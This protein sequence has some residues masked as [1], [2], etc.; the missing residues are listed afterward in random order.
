MCKEISSLCLIF[1]VDAKPLI[2]ITI[3]SLVCYEATN[4]ENLLAVDY[5]DHAGHRA[6]VTRVAANMMFRRRQKVN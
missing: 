2:D 6:N 3:P 4:V 1:P 5:Q